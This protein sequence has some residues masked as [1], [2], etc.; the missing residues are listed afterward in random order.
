[1]W[2]VQLFSA[3]RGAETA[4][5][6]TFPEDPEQ[7]ARRAAALAQMEHE[8]RVRW[9]MMHAGRPHRSRREPARWCAQE[10]QEQERSLGRV[11]VPEWR[12]EDGMMMEIPLHP[13]RGDYYLL[14][15]ACLLPELRGQV[16]EMRAEMESRPEE[17]RGRVFDLEVW[18]GV[19][20][21]HVD[22]E[23]VAALALGRWIH[24]V[25]LGGDCDLLRWLGWLQP[26]SRRVVAN[27]MLS[28]YHPD[29]S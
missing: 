20:P 10:R 15:L 17:F 4:F 5:C 22:P 11:A 12:D 26:G 16:A 7:A 9:E 8:E 18:H 28:P 1:M 14:Q 29:L 23:P 19:A 25:A 2:E 27:W 24:W 3:G 6:A 21:R 13:M